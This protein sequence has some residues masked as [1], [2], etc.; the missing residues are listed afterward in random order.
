MRRR[1]AV[2]GREHL[3]R[4]R[5]TGSSVCR[6]TAGRRR[7]T[8]DGRPTTKDRRPAT[9]QYS[10]TTR[11]FVVGVSL[12]PPSRA[13]PSPERPQRVATSRHGASAW[14]HPTRGRT[15]PSCPERRGNSRALE[16][17]NTQTTGR[18]VRPV[19]SKPSS[20]F[21]LFIVVILSYRIHLPVRVVVQT[22]EFKGGIRRLGIRSQAV[23]RASRST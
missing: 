7:T 13:R 21:I 10:P 8:D 5:A 9:T 23:E 2:R 1:D 14:F 3:R 12:P 17:P 19:R 16:G 15:R 4:A 22:A 18:S 6:T 11:S 20:Y